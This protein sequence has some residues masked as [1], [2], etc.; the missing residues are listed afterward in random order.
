MLWEGDMNRVV[1]ATT[2]NQSSS[3]SHCIFTLHLKCE[4]NVDNMVRSSKF[5]FVDLA[6]SERVS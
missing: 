3:R 5:H 2:Q 1:T 4:N 6:G